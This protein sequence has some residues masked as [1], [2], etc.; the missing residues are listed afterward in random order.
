MAPAPSFGKRGLTGAPLGR[1]P[2][3]PRRKRSNVVVVGAIGLLGLGA[4]SAAG[5]QEYRCWPPEEGQPD[6]R[7]Q[8]CFG[9]GHS[10]GGGH[11]F[12]SGGGGFGSAHASFGGFG[13]HGAGH[14]GGT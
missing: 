11:A 1:P 7:P 9:H 5:Y 10:G 4:A 6:P 13:A 12:F 2:P 14:G 8:W 3:P